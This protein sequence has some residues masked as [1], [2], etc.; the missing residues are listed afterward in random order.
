MSKFSSIKYDPFEE[1][2]LPQSM[3]VVTNQLQQLEYPACI[4]QSIHV[5]DVV[6]IEFTI[7]LAAIENPHKISL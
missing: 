2:D 1:D 3:V 7:Y 4:Q 5:A 6:R